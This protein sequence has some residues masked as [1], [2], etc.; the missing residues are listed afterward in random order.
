MADAEPIQPQT[1]RAHHTAGQRLVLALNCLIVVLCFAAA[2]GLM[3]GKSF[4]ESGKKV[5]I[6]TGRKPASGQSPQ[7]PAGT[8][9]PGETVLPDTG[10]PE[11]FPIADPTAQ[12]FLITGAD[13][14]ACI[15]PGS[16]YAGAFGARSG[17]RS[18]T[19]MIM[20]VD[21]STNLAAVLSFPR[22]LYVKIPDHGKSRINGAYRRDDPQLLIDT[23]LNEFNVPVDHFMQIDF[24][25]FKEIVDAVKGVGVPLPFAVRDTNTGLNVP[26]PGCFT[27]TGDHALAYVRSRHLQYMDDAT[28]KWRDDPSADRGRIARQQDFLRRTMSAA[29]NQKGLLDPK[30][31]SSLYATY[32]DD[33][34]VDSGLSPAKMIEFAGVLRKLKPAGVRTYQIEATGRKIGGADVL[35][36]NDTKNMTDIL[37]IFR[38]LA[39][40]AGAPEQVIEATSTTSTIARTPAD[41]PTSSVPTTTAAP[42]TGT[43]PVVVDTAPQSNA[44]KT[45]I[46]P[47]PSI[48]C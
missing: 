22:D 7:P 31:I 32:K 34:V 39:P 3:I 44:P 28:G 29:L 35:I 16:P 25:A 8:A 47:D 42:P 41:A 48:Q 37:N 5:P 43:T 11:T 18:D 4:G 40:M 12:N 20:R 14:N 15:D 36:F 19:I 45:A 33:L 27:F 24:C 9:A 10:T 46:V 23:I 17:E 21:P 30:V 1:F 6:F 38:G 26:Q 2:I 13:N